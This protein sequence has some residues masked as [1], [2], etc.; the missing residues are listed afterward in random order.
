MPEATPSRSSKLSG[1]PISVKEDNA[2][3][4]Q[5]ILIAVSLTAGGV[6]LIVLDN[7]ECWKDRL[8]AGVRGVNVRKDE[9]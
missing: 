6:V 5:R 1:P 9:M 4:D 3:K 7:R 2:V 8:V